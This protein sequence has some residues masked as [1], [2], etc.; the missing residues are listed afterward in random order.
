MSGART[1]CLVAGAT[2]ATGRLLVMELL[3]RGCD[4]RVVV[5]SRERLPAAIRDDAR[6]EVIEAAILDLSDDELAAHVAGCSAIASC[7]GHNLTFRGLFGAPR[8]LVTEAAERLCR[9]AGSS[10]TGP[11]RFVLMNTT[12]NVDRLGGER[13]SF[14][15]R[16]VLGFLRVALPPHADNEQAA[17]FLQQRLPADAGVEWA[18]VRPDALHDAEAVSPYDVVPSPTRSAIFNSGKTSRINVAH[19]MATLMTEHDVWETWK[20]RLPVV[21]DEVD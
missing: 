18:V 2:G 10:S 13:V 19:F 17:A 8:R 12:G 1:T 16:C 6:V 11:V 7:L 5:R 4:V 14:A 15:E 3:E 20:T 21:Y 9:A